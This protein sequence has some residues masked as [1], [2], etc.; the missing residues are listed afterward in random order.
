[1]HI[2]RLEICQSL[3]QLVMQSTAADDQDH[4]FINNRSCMQIERRFSCDEIR[5]FGA[6]AQKIQSGK[7]AGSRFT[8]MGNYC[9]EGNDFDSNKGI[10]ISKQ[11]DSA[12]CSPRILLDDS[13]YNGII[14][15]LHT[16]DTSHHSTHRTEETR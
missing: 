11:Y 4:R 7:H 10:R 8:V 13:S 5:A 14:S 2:D 1:M 16:D 15:M 12:A 3:D 6:V 9:K